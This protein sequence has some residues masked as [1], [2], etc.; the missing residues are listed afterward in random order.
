MCLVIVHMMI[1]VL[2]MIVEH[3][4]G[5]TTT[6]GT[7]PYEDHPIQAFLF[8]SAHEARR[9]RIQHSDWAIGS[10]GE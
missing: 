1:I 7:V 10:A 9:I 5:D 8:D 4:F 3:E 6:Q 2:L